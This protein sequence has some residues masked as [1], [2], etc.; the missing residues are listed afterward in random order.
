MMYG[1]SPSINDKG[2]AYL[3][4]KQNQWKLLDTNTK[5]ALSNNFVRCVGQD[6]NGQIWIGTD[7]GGI[8]IFDKKKNSIEVVENN[9]YNENSISQNSII[10]IFCE[11]DGT[12][13][14]GT[15]KKGLSYYHPNMFKFKKS[16]LFYTFNHN[17]EIFDC[18]SLYKDKTDNL[19]IGT[20]G[21]GLIKYNSKTE[22]IKRFKKRSQK[23]QKYICRHHNIHI[24]RSL[25][26][27][28]DRNIPRRHEC[29]RRKRI[30]TV[31][32]RRKQF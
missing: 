15:Y 18:N 31:P 10:S 1:Y 11:E 29:I 2:T 28:V 7:H 3:N 19:W 22:E 6:S 25:S 9:I 12:V 8:N 17:A 27:T 30:Q 23:F 14:V 21:K 16:P 32:D 24:R 4:L 26:D 20:N 5:V 13:W